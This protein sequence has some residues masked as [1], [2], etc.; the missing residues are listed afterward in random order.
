[1]R[2]WEA[3]ELA[4]SD[5][6]CMLDVGFVLDWDLPLVEE[7]EILE[8]GLEGVPMIAASRQVYRTQ[9]LEDGHQGEGREAEVELLVQKFDDA[10][11]EEV[12]AKP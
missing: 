11:E 3:D 7:V 2:G 6:H 4:A 8:G 9:F 12:E 5:P 1:L 10:V